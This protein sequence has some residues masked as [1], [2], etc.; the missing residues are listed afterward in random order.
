MKQDE[1]KVGRYY[2][3]KTEEVRC[4]TLIS[5]E[6]GNKLYVHWWPEGTGENVDLRFHKRLLLKSFAAWATSEVKPLYHEVLRCPGCDA[7]GW[8]SDLNTE[9]EC[10]H[11]RTPCNMWGK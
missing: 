4:V 8:V 3:G 1:I 7:W 5:G 6:Q 9:S 11:C 2:T 10:E